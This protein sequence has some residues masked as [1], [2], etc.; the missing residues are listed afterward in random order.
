MIDKPEKPTTPGMA[1]VSAKFVHEAEAATATPPSSASLP[2]DPLIAL[3][4]Q[5]QEAHDNWQASMPP[6]SDGEEWTAQDDERST[7]LART[8]WGLEN[9]IS[10]LPV[11]SLND[12][13]VKI[14]IAGAYTVEHFTNRHAELTRQARD[15]LERL[16]AASVIP[17]TSDDEF[18][19]LER[20]MLALDATLAKFDQ[21]EIADKKEVA[22]EVKAPVFEEWQALQDRLGRTPAT[23]LPGLAV[24][25][26]LL[27][28]E[29]Q[30]YPIEDFEEAVIQS[31]LECAERMAQAAD[32]AT[33]AAAP[34][35]PGQAQQCR[36]GH[37]RS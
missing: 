31:A 17:A 32:V 29:N 34:I 21:E 8:T 23:T 18:L 27:A 30:T 9:Q 11:L 28:N 24:K 6:R 1:E 19:A 16:V 15:G 7:K 26:R 12:A 22:D 33:T 5:W 36:A 14:R 2:D 35:S 37:R 3:G 20:R 25:L 4:E 10:K 13:V